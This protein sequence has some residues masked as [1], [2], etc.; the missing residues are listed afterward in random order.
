LLLPPLFKKPGDKTVNEAYTNKA[1]AKFVAV[2]K[3]E[4]PHCHPRTAFS[5]ETPPQSTLLPQSSSSNGGKVSRRS[6]YYLFADISPQWTL[7]IPESELEL[8]GLS[9]SQESSWMIC[10]GVLLTIDKNK[11]ADAFRW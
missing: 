1:L 6:P 2:S 10:E 9:L 11:F 3:Q 4:R 5:K 8:A 7:S